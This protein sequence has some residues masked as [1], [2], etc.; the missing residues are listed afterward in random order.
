MDATAAEK[1][2]PARGIVGWRAGRAS[3]P[4]NR[5]VEN[6]P[7]ERMSSGE[8]A[9]FED[10]IGS[11]VFVRFRPERLSIQPEE[12][13]E[14]ISWTI[15]ELLEVEPS[16]IWLWGEHFVAIYG[17]ALWKRD[18]RDFGIEHVGITKLRF[19]LPFSEIVYLLAIIEPE[20]I[21]RR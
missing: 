18:E 20:G 7:G 21:E 10:F 14:P 2:L 15:G 8:R 12:G 1:N 11:D 3:C 4:H 5:E 19:F 6:R 9:K 13:S 17:E 16:G